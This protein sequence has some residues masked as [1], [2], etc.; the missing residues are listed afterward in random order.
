MIQGGDFENQDGTGG[1]ASAWYGYCNGQ[2][3]GT[4]H[5]SGQGEKLGQF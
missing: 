1:Y 5:I 2:A 4:Q 3:S